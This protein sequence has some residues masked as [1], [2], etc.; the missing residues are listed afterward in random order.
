M[1]FVLIFGFL[2]WRYQHPDTRETGNSNVF[3]TLIV[4]HI[5][6]L[7]RPPVVLLATSIAIRNSLK[8]RKSFPSLSK[9]RKIWDVIFEAFPGTDFRPFGMTR[10]WVN[11]N[12][13]HQLLEQKFQNIGGPPGAFRRIWIWL[14]VHL[15][16]LRALT[17]CGSCMAY[18]AHSYI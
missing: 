14:W 16:L 1:I 17:Q 13:G 12:Q 4:T 9:I 3:N 6:F 8:S 18:A 11:T 15:E 5:R 10:K 2:R 7:I